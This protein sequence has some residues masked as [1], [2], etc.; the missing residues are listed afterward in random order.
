MEASVS[1]ATNQQQQQQGGVAPADME[2]VLANGLR[3]LSL[4]VG[5]DCRERRAVA[6]HQLE[7]LEGL[8]APA[9]GR[10]LMWLAVQVKLYAAPHLGATLLSDDAVSHTY[11]AHPRHPCIVS[12]HFFR[13]IRMRAFSRPAA[14]LPPSAPLPKA[15]ATAVAPPLSTSCPTA[16]ACL[17]AAPPVRPRHRRRRRR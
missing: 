9:H 15:A 6:R 7:M 16:A 11:T 2:G 8:A 5:A 3:Q 12:F 13:S 4:R 10:V 1:P 17:R 14:R